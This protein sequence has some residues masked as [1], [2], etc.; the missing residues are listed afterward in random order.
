MDVLER[1]Y[2]IDIN[3]A[4]ASESHISIAR[5]ALLREIAK[6]GGAR[7]RRRRGWIGATALA[8]GVTVTVVA[9]NMIVPAHVDPAA[10][11]VLEDAA[12][13]TINAIDATLAPGQ[14]LRIQED[15]EMLW[16]WDVDM[17]DE[18]SAR[19]N[20][21]SRADAEAGIIVQETRVLY[22]PAD[23]SS[24]WIW[25]WS[26]DG[27]VIQTYG[28]RVDEALA[29]W[30]TFERESDSGYWPDIQVLPGGEYPNTEGGSHEYLLDDYRRQYVEMP[31]DP[32]ALLDWFRAES[33][34]PDAADQW[35][36][37]RIADTLSGNL[38]P[39]DLRAAMLRA[40]ALVPG[41][42][43]ADTEGTHTTLEYSSG[44]WL[45]TR[46]TQITIDTSLGMITA[47]SQSDTNNVIG[48]GNI[49]RTVPGSRTVVST[50]VVD[51]API[52]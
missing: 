10:A 22:V 7:S 23:R 52:P 38:M 48:G 21:W 49:P 41:I 36:V 14:Y 2:D 11:S 20:N 25:D 47:I 15:G 3:D 51:E 40:L 13:V 27:E 46:T 37:S 28:S 34:D 24:D 39:A 31:R 5:Q 18:P 9:I 45:W 30:Q 8:G 33:G 19:F 26:A 6:E 12:E 32:Q 17:G 35:V 16:E 42:R 50:S 44:D 4:A 1:V 43:V 29:D